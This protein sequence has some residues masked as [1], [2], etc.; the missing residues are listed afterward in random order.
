[1]TIFFRLLGGGGGYKNPI[2]HVPSSN[3]LNKA[4]YKRY[5]HVLAIV[6]NGD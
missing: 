1:M 2:Q 3:E 6:M 4:E 5:S